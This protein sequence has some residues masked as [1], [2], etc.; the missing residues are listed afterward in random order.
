M[1]SALRHGVLFK[2]KILQTLCLLYNMFKNNAENMQ[3]HNTYWNVMG[4]LH[5]DYDFTPTFSNHFGNV[6]YFLASSA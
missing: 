3:D 4:I 1:N 2:T 6:C 5:N